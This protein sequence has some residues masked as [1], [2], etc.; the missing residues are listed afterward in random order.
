MAGTSLRATPSLATT[1]ARRADN[2]NSAPGPACPRS[3]VA[4]VRDSA[5]NGEIITTNNQSE[6][7]QIRST[8]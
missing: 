2:L 8:D 6:P 3:H 1:L 5:R 7:Q 4:G